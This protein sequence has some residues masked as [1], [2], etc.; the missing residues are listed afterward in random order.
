[1]RIV[2]GKWGSRELD[3]PDASI[4]RPMPDRVK[5][6]IFDM[7]GVRFE[8]PGQLPAIRVGDFFAG[9][10]SLGL[11]A[12]SRGASECWFFERHREA[13]QVLQNNITMLGAEGPATIG[14]GDAWRCHLPDSVVAPFQLIFLDPPYRDAMD[15]TTGGSVLKLMRRISPFAVPAAY[16]VLHHPGDVEYNNA[17]AGDWTAVTSRRFG[18][19]G[20]TFFQR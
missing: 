13:M 18:T 11:E 19:N 17:A 8:C 9:S 5:Q 7:L 16:L 4:T 10:G 12:L 20:V 3:H 14:P 15:A 1:M 6:A 2:A